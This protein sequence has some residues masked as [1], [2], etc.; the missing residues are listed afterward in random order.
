MPLIAVYSPKGGVGKTTLVANLCHSFSIMGL[1][2]VAIDFDPQNS[3]KLHF[4]LSVADERGFYNNISEFDDLSKYIIS[5]QDNVY[6]LPHGPRHHVE[7]SGSKSVD[8]KYSNLIN[9]LE[10]LLQQKNLM[11]VVDLQTA[12]EEI[13]NLLAPFT[14]ICLIPLLSETASLALLPDVEKFIEEM[15]SNKSVIAPQVILNQMDYRSQISIDVES[16]VKDHL[17]DN[18]FGVIHKD[19]TVIEANA[20]QTSV[21]NIN[22]SSMSAFDINAISQKLMD[23]LSVSIGDGFVHQNIV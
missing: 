21:F 8:F 22:S 11:V 19:Q 1:K 9:G 3:L 10:K 13:V 16:F 20:N 23:S 6:V 18:F 7:G 2:S 14:D 4:G 5:E 15:S 12:N 17:R